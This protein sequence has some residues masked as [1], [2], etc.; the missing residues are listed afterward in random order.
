MCVG[1]LTFL[2]NVWSA[3]VGN[4][5]LMAHQSLDYCLSYVGAALRGRSAVT[6]C[7]AMFNVGVGGCGKT[8]FMDWI[9]AAVTQIY[10]YDPPISAMDKMWTAYK[11][12]SEIAPSVRFLFAPELDVKTCIVCTRIYSWIQM[13]KRQEEEDVFFHLFVAKLLIK[14]EVEVF[15]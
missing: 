6:S 9:K 4:F 12:F 10:Y 3:G 14:R 7:S 5:V 15:C 8:T 13:K 1:R 2:R 11:S